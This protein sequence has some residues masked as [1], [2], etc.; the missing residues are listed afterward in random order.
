MNQ[1]WNQED[2]RRILVLSLI[3]C[4]IVQIWQDSVYNTL[5]KKN[6]KTQWGA[7]GQKDRPWEKK[8]KQTRADVHTHT[9]LRF[10]WSRDKN[11]LRGTDDQTSCRQAR[12]HTHTHSITRRPTTGRQDKLCIKGDFKEIKDLVS[13]KIKR[14]NLSKSAVR[15]VSPSLLVSPQWRDWSGCYRDEST[16]SSSHLFALEGNKLGSSCQTDSLNLHVRLH[17]DRFAL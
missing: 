14:Q 17:K 6:P 16:F 8:E 10:S 15:H 2:N 4:F 12:T 5:Q 3:S 13:K 11:I 7:L 9:A 1:H